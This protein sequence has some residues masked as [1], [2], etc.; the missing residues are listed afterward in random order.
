MHQPTNTLDYSTEPRRGFR[1]RRTILLILLLM[2]VAALV[3]RLITVGPITSADIRLD[4]GDLRY[5]FFGIPLKYH[6]M[7]EPARSI[8]LR[9]A[10][11]S[12]VLKPEWHTCATY[13]LP[14]SNNSDL[15]CSGFYVYAT[16]WAKQD[17]KLA[18]R[19]LEDVATYIRRTNATHGL[20]DSCTLLSPFFIT[21]DNAGKLV[22]KPDWR[23]DQNFIWYCQ[24]KGI[25]I[26]T[27]RP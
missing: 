22:L 27:A 17:P 21:E 18:Q 15:M 10:S 12:S 9:L 6:R 23:K 5:R 1:W 24:H 16:V 8:L 7:G 19:M 25:P 26:P 2:A 13:P 4:T 3:R 20:P 11:K 14:S